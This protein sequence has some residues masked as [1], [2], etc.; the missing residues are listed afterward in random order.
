MEILP[1]LLL[2]PYQPPASFGYVSCANPS[3]FASVVTLPGSS[4]MIETGT[5]SIPPTQEV[6]RYLGDSF[7]RASS[8][9]RRDFL[10]FFLKFSAAWWG[11][12]LQEK[13]RLRSIS[14]NPQMNWQRHCSTGSLVPQLLLVHISLRSFPLRWP[15]VPCKVHRWT[16]I[17]WRSEHP[18]EATVCWAERHIHLFHFFSVAWQPRCQDWS[19]LLIFPPR[20]GCKFWSHVFKRLPY[21]S[22]WLFGPKLYVN[23]VPLSSI[24]LT[25]LFLL[26]PRVM[27]AHQSMRKNL[28][29]VELFHVESVFCHG[30]LHFFE[31][32]IV[33]RD[34]WSIIYSP[35]ESKHHL[36]PLWNPNNSPPHFLANL[37]LLRHPESNR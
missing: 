2:R 21:T 33:M 23:F 7:T 36:P 8:S 1:L 16:S 29:D 31:G 20:T 19:K 18:S 28:F 30:F 15:T 34:A 5:T 32:N 24:F 6:G 14:S 4:W 35:V 37:G 13:L 26:L 22:Q 9:R 11:K 12:V 10:L 3:P 27:G 17:R 25:L